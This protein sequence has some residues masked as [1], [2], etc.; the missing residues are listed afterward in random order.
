MRDYRT[1]PIEISL[2][3]SESSFSLKT[4]D[5]YTKVIY[6]QG[7]AVISWMLWKTEFQI[8]SFHTM[9]SDKNFTQNINRI[10]SYE[11]GETFSGT[12]SETQ[13]ASGNGFKFH[14]K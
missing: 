13:Y 9:S 4:H 1:K 11:H 6:R 3:M 8:N 2:K 7:R 12:I 5:K 10:V 14:H